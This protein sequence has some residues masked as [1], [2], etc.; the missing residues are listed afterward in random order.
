M[1]LQ[2]AYA[3]FKKAC[4]AWAD[5]N[6]SSMGAALA[7]YTVFSLAPV[8]II[9]ISVVGIAFGQKVAEGEFFSQLQGLVGDSGARAIQAIVQSAN[10]PALGMV[11]SVIGLG[12]L[13]AGAS[14]A[15]V[16]LQDALNKIWKVPR[17]SKRVWLSLVRG[18]FLSF[19]LV[20]VLGFLLLVSLVVT[21]ALGA[22]GKFIAPVIPWPVIF[23]QTVN[24][25]LSL[26]V[27]GLLL[28]MI[29]KFLPD[30]DVAWRD[31]WLGAVVAS[32]L[33]TT[34]KALIGAYL[35]QSTVTSA[36]GAAASLIIILTWVYYSAQIVLFG[37]ELTHVYSRERGSRLA[38]P[39]WG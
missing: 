34:G 16:E 14:G 18:R 26:V 13:L 39:T 3:L 5:D 15:F 10:Q 25:L 23:W 1:N 28:G 38:W 17:K 33:L 35:S 29:Y 7:F 36:Y 12:T 31:V 27:I 21:A 2:A 19:A 37:A 6:A 32:M 4:L 9:A 22:I 8:L 20:L 11:A 30:A 24:Y